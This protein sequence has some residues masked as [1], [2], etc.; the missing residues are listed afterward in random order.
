VTP[1]DTARGIYDAQDRLLTYSTCRYYYSSNGDLTMKVD[2]LTKDTTRCSYDAFGSLRSVQLPDGTLLEYLIDGSGR[3]VGRKVNGA[4]TQKWLYS[5]DLRIVAEL[6]SANNIVSRFFYTSSENVP[7]YFTKAGVLYRVLTDHIG[8]VRQVVNAQTGA[9]VQSIDYDDFGNVLVDT[10]PGFTPFGFAGG[11]Y[12]RQTK[13][14]RFGARDY[15]AS[16]GRWAC[17]D[18]MRFKAGQTNFFTYAGNN[19]INGTD[20]TGL[21]TE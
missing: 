13:L 20:P 18:K 5:N 4:I 17:V 3:R 10:N 9:I 11:L 16:I 19:P 1:A 21:S 7:E 8:S 6:D 15:E 12:D 14:V 2:T